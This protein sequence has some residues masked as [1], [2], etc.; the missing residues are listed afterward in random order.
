MSSEGTYD[1][2]GWVVQSLGGVVNQPAVLLHGFMQDARGWQT[3]AES[4]ARTYCVN[5]PTIT[6]DSPSQANLESLSMGV[7]GVVQHAIM[8]TGRTQVVLVG[9]SMGGR[10]AI[11]FV[12]RY[13]YLV[14]A[15]VLESAGLGPENEEH[16]AQLQQRAEHNA[17]RIEQAASIE[18]A[19]DYWE[20]L[21]LF[22][23]QQEL[24][25]EV[26]EA[27]RLERLRS[28]KE[29]LAWLCRAAGAHTMPPASE[30]R[31]MLDSLEAPVLYV[32]GLRDPRYSGLAES[33]KGTSVQWS[34][35]DA[36]HN[37]HLEKPQEYIEVLDRF[38][39]A[40]E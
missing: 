23:T 16:R 28:T 19:V 29:Q 10:I 3:V 6:V 33:F 4:L 5:V 17:E 18:E 15:L 36:G 12:R 34:F 27:V 24:D 8:H 7:L 14:K 31:A 21:P 20:D 40:I 39:N 26:R 25:E 2:P 1:F 9:Y 35:I 13:P 11:E 37:V 30:T 32:A 38:L 22:R